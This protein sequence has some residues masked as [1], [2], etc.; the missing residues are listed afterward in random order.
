[1]QG[2]S[3]WEDSEALPRVSLFAT[4]FIALT[5]DHDGQMTICETRTHSTNSL[6]TAFV[7]PHA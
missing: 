1:M 3:K 2:I 7:L 5:T 4:T 6:G